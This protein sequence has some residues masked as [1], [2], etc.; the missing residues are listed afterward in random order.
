[1]T[2]RISVEHWVALLND[3]D[4]EDEDL[5]GLVERIPAEL[6]PRIGQ[7]GGPAIRENSS[8]PC[9]RHWSARGSSSGP[10]ATGTVRRSRPRPSTGPTQGV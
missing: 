4:L 6:V 2:S 5:E 10:A 9:L 3:A 7:M 1:V 8:L